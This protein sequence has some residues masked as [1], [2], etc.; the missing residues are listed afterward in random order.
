MTDQQ[1]TALNAQM[2]VARE[3]TAETRA[4]LDR[5]EKIINSGPEGP[6]QI[7]GAV[8]ET[9]NNPIIVKLRT[10]YLELVNR[11]SDWSRRFGKDHQ[12][13][14][15][16]NR[17]IS[18]VRASIDDELKRIAE[19]YKSEYEIAAQR[20]EELEKTI[21]SAVSQSQDTG[22]AQSELRRLES[23]AEAYRGLYK[24]ALQRNTEID[25]QQSFPGSEARL[26]TRATP[27]LEKSG[28]K[29]LLVLL[30]SCA[31][32]MML[33]FTLGMARM[34]LERVFR[35]ADQVETT[36]QA[37]SLSLIPLLA[38]SKRSNRAAKQQ[39]ERVIVRTDSLPWQAV[40]KPL[41]RFAEALRSIK[42]AAEMS[43]RPAK[44]LGF[45]S[46]LPGEGKSMVGCAYSL[47]TAQSGTRL[48]LIDCDLRNPA[49][50]RTLAP[51]AEYGVV[52][53]ITGKKKL[54]EVIWT[55][56]ETNLV[57]LPGATKPRMANSSDILA[58]A[59]LRK[60]FADLR[61]HYDSVVVD[62]PPIAPIVD[63]RSTA[64]LVDAYV[65]M[66]EW[67]RTKIDV[68]EF[69]LKKAPVVREN[70]LGVVLNKVDFKKLGR[71]DSYRS[72][73]YSDKYYVQYGTPE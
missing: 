12:A 49:L 57:F 8:T 19:T 7:G 14:V 48:I 63:V 36:L 9:L 24:S 37:T 54:E 45:T 11:E 64:G 35:T 25:N 17:Q 23:S 58:S 65:F 53:V 72:D 51:K 43:A 42:S 15:N 28:P 29:T 59:D 46:S 31:G 70:L 61:K 44:V 34:S 47:L 20:Q 68:A 73:Y 66:V 50:T 32:G 10:E 16:L 2:V 18:E 26:I 13:V 1:L 39:G 52:D 21:A 4:R 30:A 3:K 22:Q 55:D 41:S 6:Q 40:D 56:P 27:P 69:A 62:L 5:I 67:S 60:L 38:P 71:Y 33:G